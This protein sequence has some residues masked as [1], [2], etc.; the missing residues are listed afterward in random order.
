MSLGRRVSFANSSTSTFY[1][2]EHSNNHLQ[3]PSAASSSS[4]SSTSTAVHDDFQDM[5]QL[6][7][8]L[9]ANAE[10]LYWFP[11]NHIIIPVILFLYNIY[12]SLISATFSPHFQPPRPGAKPYGRIAIVG[13][14]LTGI[15]SAAHAVAHGFEVV[16]YESEEDVGGIWSR[17]N[18]TSSLQL[19]SV[20]YRFFPSVK[21]SRGFPHRD[22]IVQQIQKV[23]KAY[24]LDKCTKF[25]TK[26]EKI[27]RHHELSTKPSEGGHGRWVV[28]DGQDGIFDAVLLAVGTCGKPKMVEFKNQ[29]SF[30]GHVLHSSQLDNADLEGK[31]VVIIGSGASGV[32]AAELCVEKNAKLA[33]VLARDDKWIIPRNTIFDIMLACQPFGREMPL[34]FIPEWLIRTFHYRDLRD[35]SPQ[36]KGL[37]EGTPIVNDMFLKHIRQGKV[38][39]KR[40]D[41]KEITPQGVKFEQR[42]K[43]SKPGDG[44]VAQ[45]E[46]ADVIVMATG[47]ERPSVEMLPDDLFPDDGQRSYKRPNLYLQNFS[48]EDWSILLTNASYMD[49][50]GTVGNWHIGLYT[51]ILLVFLLDERARPSPKG[52]KLWVDLLNWLKVKTFGAGDKSGLSFFTYTELC[53]WIITFHSFNLARLPW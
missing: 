22:E 32:E 11:W 37:F 43:A 47:F 1:R 38:S 29:S 40:G 19:N 28:N 48:T 46:T 14:G 9:W 30:H 5:N 13:A 24:D 34:S 12:Q 16:I 33:V 45:V 4:G 44:G 53:L 7:S 25:K 35:M 15:S 20:L 8:S 2:P 51:R 21:W 17:V 6:N 23:W 36:H 3:T 39:Y 18:S 52:M 10:H 27:S 41:T 42:E 31:K 49:A 26:V 50:I